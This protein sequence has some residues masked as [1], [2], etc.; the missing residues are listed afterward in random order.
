[1]CSFGRLTPP[2]PM[3]VVLLVGSH[4]DMTRYV[5]TRL[6]AE[7]WDV[8]AAVGPKEGILAL[9]QLPEVDAMVVGGP[10]AYAA[11]SKLTSR[12]RAKHPYAPVVYPT[13]ADAIGAQLLEAF[14]GEAH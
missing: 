9:E 3:P 14:G 5:A 6:Q 10:A 4:P 11:R 13:S 8:H 2:V 1:M 7:G 12:L